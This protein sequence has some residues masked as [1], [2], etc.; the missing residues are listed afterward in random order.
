LEQTSIETI[1]AFG[2][3]GERS[4]VN[5][6]VWVGRNKISAVGLTA[7]RWVTM[8]GIALNVSCDLSHF[9]QIV[10]CGIAL[11][12]RGVCSIH[13]ELGGVGGAEAPSLPSV[14][15][16]WVRAFE[17]VFDLQMSEAEGTAVELANLVAEYPLIANTELVQFRT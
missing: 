14:A 10:P 11:P 2:I 12:D 17:A 13:S 15:Q 7:S 3:Q 5:T 16:R 8:H 1:G 6:G 9:Q 4:D